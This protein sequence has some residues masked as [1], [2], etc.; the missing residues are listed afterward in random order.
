MSSPARD[1][2]PFARLVGVVVGLFVVA[3]WLPVLQVPFFWDDRGTLLDNAWLFGP[4]DAFFRESLR[5]HLGHLQPLTWWSLRADRVLLAPLLEALGGPVDNPAAPHLL[6]N[7]LLHGAT[8]SALF[9]LLWRA[10]LPGTAVVP[11]AVVRGLAAGFGTVLWA[12]HPC[13]VESVA[14]STERRD[15]LAALLVVLG[16]S[17]WLRDSR[18]GRS[19]ALG[20]FALSALAKAWVIGLPVA[21]LA[22]EIGLGGAL[23]HPDG[24]REGL[25]LA[26]RRVAPSLLVAVPAAI[27]A[28]Y[29]QA[30]AGAT[31]SVAGLSW[32]ERVV[33]AGYALTQYVAVTIWPA[34]LAPLHPIVPGRTLDAAHLVGAGVAFATLAFFAWRALGPLVRPTM[35]RSGRDEA[36]FAAMLGALGWLAPVLGLLQSGVQAWAERYL[37][38]AHIA[39]LL[40]LVGGLAGLLQRGTKILPPAP[41][42]GDG[43]ERAV[44]PTRFIPGR[45]LI[46]AMV[47]M[48]SVVVPL[49]IRLFA[50]QGVWQQGGEALWTAAIEAE[51][52]SPHALA[53][54]AALRLERDDLDAAAADLDLALALSP[55]FANALELRADVHSRR[56]ETLLAL[57]DLDAAVDAAPDDGKVRCNRGTVRAKAGDPTGARDDFD[58]GLR[59]GAGPDCHL[60]RAVLRFR[61][62]DR[63]GAAADVHAALAALPAGHPLRERAEG[64]ARALGGG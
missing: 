43:N 35:P 50:W 15:V 20:L 2:A 13:R 19:W 49:L 7:V 48:P 62:G 42:E 22:V 1:S 8:A 18:R 47:A 29:A 56:G 51:P 46:V 54:R 63:A 40:P 45:N 5:P 34:Y 16:L 10:L 53:N 11:L 27:L 60:N 28:A 37:V 9:V 25:R 21:L 59:A 64:M 23:A 14:W 6:G 57:A 58:A 31:A 3:C 12:L 24:P 33:G 26:L 30:V 17:A 41:A 4:L 61:I 44:V 36:I 38:L 39:V 52:A 32:L 55:R